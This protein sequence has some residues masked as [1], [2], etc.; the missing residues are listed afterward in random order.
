MLSAAALFLFGLLLI[1]SCIITVFF[2]FFDSSIF[3]FSLGPVFCSSRL[4]FDRVVVVV[5]PE[6]VGL[7]LFADISNI[8]GYLTGKTFLSG[9]DT[10]T[11]P[12]LRGAASPSLLLFYLSTLSH[13][14]LLSS[15]A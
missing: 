8:L 7:F 3:Y 9:V 1:V 14:L 10:C 15:K 13:R 11:R 4:C 2:S 6:L 12:L 5:V